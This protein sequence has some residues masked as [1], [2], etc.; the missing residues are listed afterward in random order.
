MA[1]SD[2]ERR[3]LEKL[4]QELA[5]SDPDLYRTLQFGAPGNKRREAA[6]TLWGALALIGA[7]TLVIVG[8]ATELVIVGAFGFLLMVAAANWLLRGYG[9]QDGHKGKP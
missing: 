4:E 5:S 1:L 8:I 9:P 3:R 2:E 7:F 6:T